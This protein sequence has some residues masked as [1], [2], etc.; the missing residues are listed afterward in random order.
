[1]DVSGHAKVVKELTDNG[2]DVNVKTYDAQT[3]I[4]FTCQ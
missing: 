1:M 3:T 4:A 2:A